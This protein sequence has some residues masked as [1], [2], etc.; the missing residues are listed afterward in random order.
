MDYYN[1]VILY[2]ISYLTYFSNGNNKIELIL[3]SNAF[4]RS[5]K[6][7]KFQEQTFFI[8]EQSKQQY[9][10]LFKFN[11]EYSNSGK[12]ILKQNHSS[13]LRNSL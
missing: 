5:L 12:C 10:I 8:T 9:F 4:L 13:V 7:H 6:K 1:I 3:K 11:L 2:L